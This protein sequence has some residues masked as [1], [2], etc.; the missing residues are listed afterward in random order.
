MLHA[1]NAAEEGDCLAS[2]ELD[3]LE[4][5]FPRDPLPLRQGLDQ[6]EPPRDTVPAPP[7]DWGTDV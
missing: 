4:A 1:G 2:F 5:A 7:P 3:E 6:V